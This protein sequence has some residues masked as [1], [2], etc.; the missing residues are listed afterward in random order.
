MAGG[1]GIEAFC[2]RSV[3][4]IL[5]GEQKICGNSQKGGKIMGSF[6]GK[7]LGLAAAIALGAAV[8]AMAEQAQFG[9]VLKGFTAGTLAFNGKVEGGSYAVS[10]V[11]KTTGLAAFLKKVRYEASASGRVSGARFSP[12]KYSEHADTGKRQSDSVLSYK[13][14]VPTL[15]SS[16]AAR[17]AEEWD[18]SATTQKGTVDPLTALFATLSDVDAGQECKVSLKMFDGRRASQIATATPQKSGDKV[19]CAG[20]Y[21]RVAGYSPE[22]MAEKTRFPFTLTYAPVEGGK[23]RVVEVSMDS[24]YGKARLVRQ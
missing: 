18:I 5:G 1:G 14:G 13:A 20:E 11:L 7:A 23:M 12:S 3:R 8:P 24:L 22:D 6:S 2:A 15:Q 4:Y 10:G 16:K 17:K 21:R 19:V 9:L